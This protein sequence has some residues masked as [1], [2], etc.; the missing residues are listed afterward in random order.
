MRLAEAVCAWQG[1]NPLPLLRCFSGIGLRGSSARSGMGM[2][3]TN[4]DA[5]RHYARNMLL[6]T[7]WMGQGRFVLQTWR[8][9][10]I[11]ASRPTFLY[12][13]S[14]LFSMEYCRLPPAHPSRASPEPRHSTSVSPTAGLWRGLH[15]KS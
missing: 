1:G 10:R 15:R 5:A 14:S 12:S 6:L 9:Q 2:N 13:D 4:T 8:S 3:V 7:A 11:G